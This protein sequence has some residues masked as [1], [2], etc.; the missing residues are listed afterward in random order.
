MR[1]A[2]ID[3]CASTRQGHI[4]VE[5]CRQSMESGHRALFCHAR[6]YCPKDI[7]SY[8]IGCWSAQ[9]LTLT[10]KSKSRLSGGAELK[11][12]I[13]L[14]RERLGSLLN[15]YGHLFFSRL[16]G[17]QGFFSRQ[18]T[19]RLV[20]QLR[21]FQ[22]DVVHLLD[23][24]GS[25]IHLPTLFEYLKTENVPVVWTLQDFWAFTGHCLYPSIAAD[26]APTPEQEQRLFSGDM[27]LQ[28][29]AEEE[30]SQEGCQR[31]LT[32]CG[33]CALKREYP[34]S[35]LFDRSATNW[36]EKRRL[37]S[38][39]EYMILA[40][41]SQWLLDEVKRSFLG[42][43]PAY[44]LPHGLDLNVFKPCVNV[45]ERISVLR[46]LRLWE[47][48]DRHILLSVAD[49]WDS[50]EGLE[51]LLDLSQKL[52]SDTVIVAVGLEDEQRAAVPDGTIIAL[53]ELGND[54]ELC[55]LY[56][57]ADL[58]LSLSRAES[59]GMRLLQSLGCGTQVFCWDTAALP[60]IV[61]PEVGAMAPVGDLSAAAQ[62]IFGLLQQPKSPEDCRRRAMEFD[63]GKRL[64]EYVRLYERM[65]ANSPAMNPRPAAELNE[66]LSSQ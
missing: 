62:Q 27:E 5:L 61:T 56:T 48:H 46:R 49:V 60:E 10:H 26:P 13:H 7:P 1:I 47:F 25:Y 44:C 63:A 45:E 58:Y 33:E 30:L 23:L 20:R 57:A 24:H 8:R 53:P 4:A 14:R 3:A 64:H 39:L 65:H 22:P 29:S 11:N 2:L 66:T 41:P 34:V 42:K 21:D 50:R 15:C 28:L 51:D 31:W 16:T 32:G 17:R 37:F 19:L 18:A 36:R 38:G 43:Y 52:G 9:N 40:A 55:A 12:A 6:G 54:Q 35:W 59:V